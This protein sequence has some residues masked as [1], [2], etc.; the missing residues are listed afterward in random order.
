MPTG[1]FALSGFRVFGEGGGTTPGAVKD[2]TI[3]RGKSERR[4][5]WIKWRLADDATGYTVYAGIAPDKL[6]NNIMVYGIN[7]YFFKG[8]DR[9]LPYYF[10][11]EA[12]NEKGRSDRTPVIKVE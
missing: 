11:I 12:F 2:F 1:K 9:D 5:A 8:M 7:E 4:N 6:Y 10:Q 3:L